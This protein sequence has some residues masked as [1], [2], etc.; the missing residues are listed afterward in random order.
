MMKF[1]PAIALAAVLGIGV[2]TSGL[3][4]SVTRVEFAKGNDNAALDGKV[5]GNDYADYVLGAKAGQTMS[6]S[7]ITQG[8]AYFNIL[9]PGSDGE[10]IYIGSMDGSD[11][12]I[13]LPTDGDYT[14]RVY[15]MGD[16]K[17][18]GKTVAYTLSF[19]IM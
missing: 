2:A 16:D 17:D 14:V 13:K 19:T 18:S 5:T 12:T 6:V 3:A 8:T 10:A 9:P 4:A 15:L 7:L 1:L 11:A